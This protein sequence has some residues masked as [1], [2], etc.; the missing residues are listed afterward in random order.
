VTVQRTAAGSA[1]IT[2]EFRGVRGT[3]FFS[4]S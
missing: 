1:T 2:A 4:V 3:F